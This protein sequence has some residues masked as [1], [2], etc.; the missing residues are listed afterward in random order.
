MLKTFRWIPAFSGG[1]RWWRARTARLVKTVGMLQSR[2]QILQ[3]DSPIAGG[4]RAEKFADR[5]AREERRRGREQRYF[6]FPFGLATV[7]Y[8]VKLNY[9]FSILQL[10]LFPR[11]CYFSGVLVRELIVKSLIQVQA[12]LFDGY[13]DSIGTIKG[14]YNANLGITKK[15]IQ[16]PFIVS[17]H[18]FSIYEITI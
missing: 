10:I 15:P 18:I 9:I 12:Y 17:E 5:N 8:L 16:L 11:K 4:K 14:F 3:L 7:I 1:C 6:P 2:M 13:W